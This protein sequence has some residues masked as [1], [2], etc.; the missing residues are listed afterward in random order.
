MFYAPKDLAIRAVV[1]AATLVPAVRRIIA[2]ADP[3]QPV[4]DVRPLADILGAET[5]TR[6]VQLRAL[7]S[8]TAVSFV[9]AA[10]GI[11]GLLA[12]RVSARFHEF[13]VRRALGAQSGAIVGMVVRQALALAAVGI[14]LG[15][16]LA[17]YAGRSLESLL[18]GISPADAVSASAAIALTLAMAAFGSIVPALRAV[19]AD[20]VRAL[21]A[22]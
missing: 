6:Q 12:F 18:A 7:V 15:A 10:L 16:L 1:P 21:R 4:S 5:E 14:G 8:F 2:N 17:W 13:G 3:Q 9:L 11:H 22:E 20:P 19:R